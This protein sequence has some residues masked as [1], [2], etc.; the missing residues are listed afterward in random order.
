MGI[1]THDEKKLNTIIKKITPTTSLIQAKEIG[2]EFIE[3][4]LYY[5]VRDSD[6][7]QQKKTRIYNK[8]KILEDMSKVTNKQKL[9]T[10]LYNILLSGEGLKTI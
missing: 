1:E 6:S 10:L 2:E 7:E 5:K 4:C 8:R 3:E 9:V